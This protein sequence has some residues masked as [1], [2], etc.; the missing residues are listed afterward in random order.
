MYRGFFPSCIVGDIPLILGIWYPVLFGGQTRLFLL[1]I[2]GFHGHFRRVVLHNERLHIAPFAALYYFT[3]FLG[4]LVL[5][6]N[7]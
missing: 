1:S 2:L 4:R 5:L 3:C 7:I 6:L